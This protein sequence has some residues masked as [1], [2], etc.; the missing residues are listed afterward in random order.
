MLPLP[1]QEGD[2]STRTFLLFLTRR[3]YKAGR[4]TLA[5]GLPY[6]EGY[7]SCLENALLGITRLPGTTF[8][9]HA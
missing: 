5:L 1:K 8:L 3:V 6:Q 2:P 7:P 4:V 9:R